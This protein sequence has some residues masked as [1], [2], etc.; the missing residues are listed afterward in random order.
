MGSRR[1]TLGWG[2]APLGEML[3]YSGNHCVDALNGMFDAMETT[4]RRCQTGKDSVTPS[5]P[6]ASRPSS[7]RI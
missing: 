2:E 1:L 5:F 7:P 6:I 3:P 4:D